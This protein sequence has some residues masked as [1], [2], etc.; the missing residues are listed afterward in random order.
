[1]IRSKRQNGS[2]QTGLILS[3]RFA[4]QIGT[5]TMREYRGLRESRSVGDICF[6][7]L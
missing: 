3:A 6:F 2:D 1:M 5:D 7:L 4:A